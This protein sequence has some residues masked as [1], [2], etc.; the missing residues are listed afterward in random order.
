MDF[1]TPPSI[2]RGD[3]I[4]LIAPSSPFDTDAFARGVSRLKERYVVRYDESIL[5]TQ[6]YL[7]GNDARRRQE[8]VTAIRNS[9]VKAIVAARGGYGATRILE[10]D[11][12]DDIRSHPK[13]L[14][15]FSDI[16]ALHAQWARAGV[17]SLHGSMV[18]TLGQ[19][20]TH[21]FERWCG[22]VEGKPMSV[23][24]NLEVISQAPR[25]G[26]PLLG[27]N[28]AVLAS[29][30]G[31]PYAPPIDGAVLFLEDTHERPYRL[32]RL[33]TTLRLAGWFSRVTGILLGPF[34]D[35]QPGPDGVTAQHVLHACLSNMRVPVL[36]G[37]PSGHIDDNAELMFGAH[38]ELDCDS[39]TARF[40]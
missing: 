7:A 26:G 2:M 8:L 36:N 24:S 31:T 32:D 16:T 34:E 12:L 14:V 23:L 3:T 27:G 6:G 30:L 18:C 13:L 17:C 29:L 33:L 38:V 9:H 22:A 28:L 20:T 25:S 4:A 10:P 15:G 5:E 21:Q 19:S 40:C 11:L 35:S 37:A 1:V 39:K